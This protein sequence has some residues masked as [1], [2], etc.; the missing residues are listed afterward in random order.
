MQQDF[1]SV[2]DKIPC[3]SIAEPICAASNENTTH[4]SSFPILLVRNMLHPVHHLAVFPLLNGDVRHGCCGSGAVPVLLAGC[5]PDH[6][7]RMDLLN[8]TAL[9]LS[10][11]RT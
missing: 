4:I 5:K 6:I 7:S 9:A 11:S 2:L 10:P 3:R 8:W 1:V